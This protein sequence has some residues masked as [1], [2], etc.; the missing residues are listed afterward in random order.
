MITIYS[1]HL[2]NRLQYAVDV[3]FKQILGLEVKLTNQKLNLE[4][5]VINYSDEKIKTKS[6]NIS[7]EGLL[8][9]KT[10]YPKV[11]DVQLNKRDLIRLFNKDDDFGFDIFSAVFFLVTRMEEYNSRDLDIHKRFKYTNSILFKY[12]VLNF[13][14]IDVWSFN[15][16]KSI[17]DFFDQN[18]SSNREFVN[19]STID[20]DNAF[21]YKNKGFF[22]T[23]GASLKSLLKLDFYVFLQRFRV[24][25]FSEKDPYDNYEYLKEFVEKEKIKLTVFILLAD[26]NKYDKNL[27]YKN[28]SFVNLIKFI[29]SFSKIGIHPSYSSYLNLNKISLEISRLENINFF[30]VNDSRSHFLRFKLPDTFQKLIECGIKNDH[31]M[32]Y[33]DIPGFR[34]GTCTPFYFYDLIE[35]K[36]TELLITPFAYMDGAFK[37]YMNY[38]IDDTKKYITK[39]LK[40]VKSINGS[41]VSV[42]HNESLSNQQRWVGWRDVYEHTFKSSF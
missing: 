32:G 19:S 13:P 40:N 37:D 17:N 16:L 30:K 4:G 35:E 42:W 20:I 21:A 26:Y 6:F 27:N 1:S 36:Q 31:S 29:S 25:F 24:L 23:F 5:V 34:A 10:I 7:P 2:S 41:F 18:I 11:D 14:I 22:R 28:K 12:D 33:A 39:L 38:S 9:S 3:V 8:A 15:L